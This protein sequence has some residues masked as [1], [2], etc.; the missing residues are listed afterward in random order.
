VEGNDP[1]VYDHDDEHQGPSE[2]ESAPIEEAPSSSS[3]P[4][5]SVHL[6]H[7]HHHHTPHE[8]HQQILEDNLRDEG[9]TLTE[10]DGSPSITP[11]GRQ[12]SEEDN[13]L[14]SE[15]AIQVM[16]NGRA[17][18]FD[19]CGACTEPTICHDGV[20]I[21]ANGAICV[22]FCS[23]DTDCLYRFQPKLHRSFPGL[24][25]THLG[26]CHGFEFAADKA[27]SIKATQ[28]V[29]DDWKKLTQQSANP[30]T[31][32]TENSNSETP[33]NNEEESHN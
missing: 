26:F 4:A 12:N 17:T 1:T 16:F 20:G 23:A 3:P 30:T 27:G 25:L 5:P 6:D 18:Y 32:S 9:D 28:A 29:H 33:Q 2:D 13:Q 10:S 7:S 19:N 8:T 22:Q 11:L 21:G 31:P 14:A 24:C 15:P